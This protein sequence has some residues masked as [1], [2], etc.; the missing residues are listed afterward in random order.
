[1]MLCWPDLNFPPV[2]QYVMIS[3]YDFCKINLTTDNVVGKV[4]HPSNKLKVE[5]GSIAD[6]QLKVTKVL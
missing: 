5:E 2:N 1:M 4:T 6:N 3:H